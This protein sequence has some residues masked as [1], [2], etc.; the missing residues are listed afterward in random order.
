MNIEPRFYI[1]C[2]KNDLYNK[3]ERVKGEYSKLYL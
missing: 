1:V 2:K 3:T